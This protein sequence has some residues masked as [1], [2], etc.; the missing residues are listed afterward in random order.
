MRFLLFPY[1]LKLVPLPYNRVGR[2]PEVAVFSV[3]VA[4]G[5]RGFLHK[6]TLAYLFFGVFGCSR[7]Y[8][9]AARLLIEDSYG[10]IDPQGV[11]EVFEF[12]DA[13]SY[14]ASMGTG[15]SR[16]FFVCEKRVEQD[17]LVV[18]KHRAIE[19]ERSIRQQ[20][21]AEVE[22]PVNIDPGIIN[23]CR[24][25]LASTKDYSHRIYRGE[26]I[27]EE[28]TLMYRDGAYRSLPWTYRD[29]NNPGYHAFFEAFRDRVVA[30]L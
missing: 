27:W 26:G 14:K 28:I 29:F 3:R 10:P 15:L 16:Q 18:A 12:P 24:I 17:C 30:E 22:R 6:D 11:S 1:V 13:A 8:L 9:D 20:R 7:D 2:L 4:D 23:D 25:I 21:P 5:E 19:M